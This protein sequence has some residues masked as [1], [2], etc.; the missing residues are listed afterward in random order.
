MSEKTPLRN[1]HY[2]AFK[3]S[4]AKLIK[5]LPI[6]DLLP[7]LVSAGVLSG[8]L[9]KRMDATSVES[10]KVK[11]MLDGMEGGL[12]AQI[13]D[14]FEE[15]I[16]VIEQF[17]IDESDMVVGKLA[18]DIRALISASPPEK[19][20]TES[21]VKSS[22]AETQSHPA[23]QPPN[24]QQP[25]SSL[26]AAGQLILLRTLIVLLHGQLVTLNQSHLIDF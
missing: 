5:A 13:P 1:V 4:Y 12:K 10:E 16:R 11:V 8:N 26:S 7:E 20:A 25:T 14:Q 9:K 21:E 24:R 19:G 3:K 17:S 18:K 22:V 15:F 2:E 6:N 23:A